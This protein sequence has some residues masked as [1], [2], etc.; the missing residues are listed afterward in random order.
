[1]CPV[2]PHEQGEITLNAYNQFSSLLF[3]VGS[4]PITEYEVSFGQSTPVAHIYP[5]CI[6]V[7]TMTTDT[8]VSASFHWVD[9]RDSLN[10]SAVDFSA[11]SVVENPESA[12]LYISVIPDTRVIPAHDSRTLELN[13]YRMAGAAEFSEPNG[14]VPVEEWIFTARRIL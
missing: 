13:V 5:S 7:S 6:T 9:G 10:E 4:H 8:M 14:Q 1:M 11:R 3:G 2:E 12:N